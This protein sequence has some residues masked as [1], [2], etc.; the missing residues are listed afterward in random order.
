MRAFRLIQVSDT[1]LGHTRPWF[2]P[3]FHAMAR[4]I[5][6]LRPD[7]V[8]NTGDISFNGA[9]LDEDLAFARACH[10]D[11]GVPL[12]AIPGNHDVGDNPW[13]P[14]IPQPITEERLLRYRSHFGDDYWLHDA[15]RWLLIGLNV[16]LFASGL[17]AEA[18]QWAFLASAA[19]HGRG[20]PIAL[21][22][23]KPLFHEH[24]DETDVTHRFVPL[25]HRRRLMD[26]LGG[27]IRLVA[28]GHVHQH[29]RHRVGAVDH[30]WAPST[31]YVLPDH[32]Q[33][34]LG[35][36]RVGYVDYTFEDDRVDIRVVEPEQL[37]NHDLDDFPGPYRH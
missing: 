13:K 9:E 17:A 29:R 27:E 37:I 22:I 6:M 36:K 3:N 15:G 23:H 31:A 30:A 12:R 5:S 4:I 33:P 20:R 25:E 11:L 14:G 28:S 34:R 8:V 10:A 35:I 18:E 26:L 1:H 32:R 2:A 19:A 21:F 24:A 16:Q 7:L